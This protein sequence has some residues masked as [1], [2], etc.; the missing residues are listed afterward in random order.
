MHYNRLSVALRMIHVVD[1]NWLPIGPEVAIDS[2]SS[3]PVLLVPLP[4]GQ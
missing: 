1:M 4:K 3:L 2:G